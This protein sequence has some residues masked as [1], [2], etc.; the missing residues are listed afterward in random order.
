RRMIESPFQDALT[1]GWALSMTAQARVSRSV[2]LIL[3]P[4]AA[5][6]S[7][8]SARKA[9]SA[10]ASTFEVSRNVGTPALSDRRLAVT[11]VLALTDNVVSS[12]DPFCDA[13]PGWPLSPAP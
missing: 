3:S 12:D 8:I 10:S 9:M 2:R 13:V 1:S 7:L 4:V 11:R 5:K 6:R